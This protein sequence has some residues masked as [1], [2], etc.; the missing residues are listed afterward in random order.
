MASNAAAPATSIRSTPSGKKNAAE[1]E[2][3]MQTPLRASRFLYA[4]MQCWQFFVCA[5]H[6]S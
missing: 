4:T 1:E 2:R 3:P 5:F 6:V